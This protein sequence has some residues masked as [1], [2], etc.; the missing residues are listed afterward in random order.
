MLEIASQLPT[1]F[2]LLLLFFLFLRLLH[3]V[4]VEILL[5]QKT[6][7]SPLRLHHLAKLALVG[8]LVGWCNTL[9]IISVPL[10]GNA[11]LFENIYEILGFDLRQVVCDNDGRLLLTP[12]FKCFKDEN[13]GSRV[14]RGRRLV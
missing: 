1:R 9:K 2:L 5:R 4:V 14:Q 13:T 6:A 11:T 8:L 12:S 3:S 10:L 7:C